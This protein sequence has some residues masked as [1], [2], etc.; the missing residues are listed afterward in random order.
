MVLVIHGMSLD[1]CS[2]ICPVLSQFF[3]RQSFRAGCKLARIGIDVTPG[4]EAILDCHDLLVIPVCPDSTK[5]PSVV[6][7]VAVPVRGPF[8]GNHGCQVWRLPRS[9]MPLV[10]GVVRDSEE[11]YLTTAP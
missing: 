8:P 5:N 4:S 6:G 2:Q 10:D 1:R 11:T 9:H 3:I 7:H